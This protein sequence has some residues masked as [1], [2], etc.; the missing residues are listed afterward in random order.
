MG[1]LIVILV[2]CI[3]W[4]GIKETFKDAYTEVKD[5][6]YSHTINKS[7]VKKRIVF[8]TGARIESKFR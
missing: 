2:M 8:R 4:I 6:H 7:D 3:M 1:W 5:A